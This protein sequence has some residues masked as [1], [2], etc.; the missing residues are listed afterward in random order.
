MQQSLA[1]DFL[2]ARGQLVGI[3]ELAFQ[4]AVNAAY[5]LLFAQLRAVVGTAQIFL[6]VLAGR[7]RA[8]LN[9]TLVGEA[10]LAF[11]EELL[12]FPAALAAFR[13]KVSGHAFS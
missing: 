12:A 9:G 1:R 2:G 11:E 7:V 4:H 10:L 3:A 5:L 6:A 8:A 13:V